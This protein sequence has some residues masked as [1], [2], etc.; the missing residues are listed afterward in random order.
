MSSEK[1]S[2]TYTCMLLMTKLCV[3]TIS[4]VYTIFKK[5]FPSPRH[6]NVKLVL[7]LTFAR[8]RRRLRCHARDRNHRPCRWSPS[9]WGCSS[10][11]GHGGLS[12]VTTVQTYVL[13]EHINSFPL[14]WRSK[15]KTNWTSRFISYLDYEMRTAVYKLVIFLII[16][17]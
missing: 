7:P 12:E 11:P 8:R 3:Y 17:Y 2:N 16:S 1:H 5:L 4:Q 9:L 14:L 10:R 15:I 13:N 6:Y